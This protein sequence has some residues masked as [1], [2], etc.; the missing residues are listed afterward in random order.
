MKTIGQGIKVQIDH[1]NRNGLDNR[2]ENL[3]VV[4]PKENSHNCINQSKY[5][6]VYKQGNKYYTQYRKNGKLIKSAYFD[7]P[8]QAAW[9]Y[10][11]WCINDNCNSP[12][13]I[14]LSIEEQEKI[15]Y[16]MTEKIVNPRKGRKKKIY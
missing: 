7:T 6:G 14:K 11:I 10:N 8:E 2:K 1:I 15:L 3:K 5:V 4:S 12:N 16:L 13:N 9:L